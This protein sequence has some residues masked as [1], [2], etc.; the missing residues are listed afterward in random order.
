MIDLYHKGSESQVCWLAEH[1]QDTIYKRHGGLDSREVRDIMRDLTSLAFTC[2]EMNQLVV[3]LALPILAARVSN[4]EWKRFGVPPEMSPIWQKIISEPIK[5]SGE[6]LKA[7]FKHPSA[8]SL[9]LHA[10]IPSQ[11]MFLIKLTRNQIAFLSQRVIFSARHSALSHRVQHVSPQSYG[12]IDVQIDMQNLL[13]PPACKKCVKVFI[14]SNVSGL[15]QCPNVNKK[16]I[17]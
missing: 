3:S 16:F 2:K 1:P 17:G 12:L 15:V 14:W 11:S 9:L 10:I 8:L 5:C 6:E 4:T 7:R 13:L